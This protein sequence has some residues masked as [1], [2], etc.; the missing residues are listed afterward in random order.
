MEWHE[1][2]INSD[3]QRPMK[4]VRWDSDIMEPV[5]FQEHYKLVA[6]FEEN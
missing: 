6:F 5:S 3:D 4:K 1:N 2:E